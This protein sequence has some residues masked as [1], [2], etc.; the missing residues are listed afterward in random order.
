MFTS[1]LFLNYRACERKIWKRYSAFQEKHCGK[2]F[3][4]SSLS[5]FLSQ[6]QIYSYFWGAIGNDQIRLN[7]SSSHDSLSAEMLAVCHLLMISKENLCNNSVF[8]ITN[9][10]EKFL[11]LKCRFLVG[12][13]KKYS[14]F[15]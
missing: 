14:E 3:H 7:I 1:A 12:H 4:I 13:R 9:T 10:I 15:S 8:I 5:L 6:S 11:M 2:I